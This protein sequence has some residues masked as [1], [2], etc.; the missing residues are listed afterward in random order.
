MKTCLYPNGNS[1]ARSASVALRIVAVG[2]ALL[3]HGVITGGGTAIAQDLRNNILYSRKTAPYGKIWANDLNG[4]DSVL[5]ASGAFANMNAAGTHLLYLD[6][7]DVINPAAAYFNSKLYRYDVVTDSSYLLYDATGT[8]I[9]GNDFL[10]IDSSYVY[11]FYCG[12]YKSPF[13]GSSS[14]VI[15]MADCFDDG[16]DLRQQDSM[17]VVHNVSAARLF[18]FKY[19]GSARYPVP[20]VYGR[21]VFP[22]W[23]NDGNWILYGMQHPSGSGMF[24]FY[25]IKANGDSLTKLTF[26]DSIITPA[27]SSNAAWS[28]DGDYIVAAGNY[29]GRSGLLRIAADGSGQMDTLAT[30]PGDDINWISVG[31]NV[32]LHAVTGLTSPETVPLQFYPNPAGDRIYFTGL[33]AVVDVYDITGARVC[34]VFPDKMNSWD[35]STLPAGLYLL[36]STGIR[37]SIATARVLIVH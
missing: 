29:Q 30:V 7:T 8:Y 12:I 5:V 35:V 34:T 36:R 22:M 6:N 32:N 26:Q 24:N 31:T 23:S 18:V 28:P 2:L 11:S 14:T 21:A 4:N 27:F 13:N 9:V 20:N 1:N 10:D 16:P 15:S 25:K 33:S 3:F 37:D 17:V 19:D